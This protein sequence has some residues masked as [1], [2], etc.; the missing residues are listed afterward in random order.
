MTNNLA[1]VDKQYEQPTDK[2]PDHI[3]C[4]CLNKCPVTI[5]WTASLQALPH[6]TNLSFTSIT[7]K[8]KKGTTTTVVQPAAFLQDLLS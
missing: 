6:L 7:N 1:G 2:H 4:L 5:I 3:K 8:D